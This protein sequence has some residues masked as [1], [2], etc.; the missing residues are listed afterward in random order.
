LRKKKGFSLGN[1]PGTGKPE[2]LARI[3][4]LFEEAMAAFTVAC[5]RKCAAC[6]TCNVT[7]TGLEARLIL[8]NIPRSQ[9]AP[10]ERLAAREVQK[11]RYLPLLTTNRFARYVMQGKQ[12]PDEE[13][14]PSWGPCP[15]L[16]DKQCRIYKVRPFGCRALM[17]DTACDQKGYAAMPPLAL[18]ITTVF[19]QAVEHLDE[20]GIFGNLS[21]VL[22][23]E[24]AGG[25]KR[26]GQ[27]RHLLKNEPIPVL[28]VPEEHRRKLSDLIQK[29]SRIIQ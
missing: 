18:T 29:L 23:A 15:L 25:K 26:V 24:M 2:R 5:K 8:E 3:Y 13:N 17:S 12:I 28:M 16:K 11:K 9:V 27:Q 1:R 7:M 10:L 20:G 4:Q 19:Q 21:D 22:W 14:D 6:C